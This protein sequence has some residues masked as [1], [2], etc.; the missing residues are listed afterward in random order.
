MQIEELWVKR[1]D[2]RQTRLIRHEAQDLRWQ[3]PTREIS[4]LHLFSQA[5][6]NANAHRW[7]LGAWFSHQ[8]TSNRHFNR[9]ATKSSAAVTRG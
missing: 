9:Q 2:L 5:L 4:R 1:A 8:C 3:E 7:S 6:A